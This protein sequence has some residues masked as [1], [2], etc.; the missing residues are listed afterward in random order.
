MG[1][2]KAKWRMRT[3]E[4]S[5]KRWISNGDKE[6]HREKPFHRTWD[7]GDKAEY[8]NNKWHLTTR[9]CRK[10]IIF[11]SDAL[12]HIEEEWKRSSRKKVE[13]RKKFLRSFV[14][15]LRDDLEWLIDNHLALRPG[16]PRCV[17]FKVYN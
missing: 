15:V 6:P 14:G 12:E 2:I 8:I 11:V 16:K 13:F 3:Q 7:N 4:P 1:D 17:E 5:C 9:K 10:E